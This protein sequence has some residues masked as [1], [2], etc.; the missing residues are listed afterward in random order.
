MDLDLSSVES[1][2][3]TSG[4]HASNERED[5]EL[6]HPKVDNESRL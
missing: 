2:E 4:S 1:A 6:S 3:A 5:I